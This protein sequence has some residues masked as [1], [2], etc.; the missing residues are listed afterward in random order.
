MSMEDFRFHM[1]LTGRLDT[2]R[3]EACLGDAARTGFRQSASR[4]SRSTA[5]RYS[6]RKMQIRD[7]GSSTT[8]NF[9]ARLSP[10]QI[11]NPSGCTAAAS[12]EP[13]APGFCARLELPI[14]DRCYRIR[15]P[16]LAPQVC[17]HKLQRHPNSV[18]PTDGSASTASLAT[19]GRSSCPV[20][21]EVKS[22]C[23]GT[24]IDIPNGGGVTTT[25]RSRRLSGVGP[26]CLGPPCRPGERGRLQ[27]ERAY[28]G[29]KTH[30]HRR[31]KAARRQH[32]AATSRQPSRHPSDRGPA[33]RPSPF[34]SSEQSWTVRRTHRP[35]F[36]EIHARKRHAR[37]L[38]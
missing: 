16:R 36:Q 38:R 9:R 31:A 4:C 14:P 27:R 15:A 25:C 28:I 29:K 1:T 19:N 2:E 37:F 8:G 6:V 26:L 12:P 18:G 5:S 13:S 17:F 24:D 35:A 34:A 21:R 33:H 11:G 7:S 10:I 3:R 32:Q 20:T 30:A 22:G 23:G